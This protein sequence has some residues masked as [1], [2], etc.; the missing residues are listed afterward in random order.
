M[1][2]GK[3]VDVVYLDFFRHLINLVS[4]RILLYKLLLLA[5][6]RRVERWIED[7]FG[8]S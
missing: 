1:G 8:W 3:A 2:A 6:G 4:L 5:F 7:F